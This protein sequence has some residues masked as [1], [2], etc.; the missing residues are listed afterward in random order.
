MHDLSYNL[1]YRTSFDVEATSPEGDALWVVVQNIRRWICAKW[2]RRGV[3]IPRDDPA[4]SAFK[5]GRDA[6]LNEGQGRVHFESAAI[7]AGE[8]AE[9]WACS[10]EETV[11]S[12]VPS[13]APRVWRTEVG[14]VG[15]SRQS[16][17]LSLILSYGDMPGFVGPVQPTPTASVPNLVRNLASDGRLSCTCS[18]R[19]VPTGPIELSAGTVA[20]FWAFVSDSDR[21]TP[22][23][24]VSPLRTASR[25]E[26]L[27]V[28]PEAI[29]RA[30]GP[31][32]FVFFTRDP[33]VIGELETHIGDS[34]LRCDGGAMRVYAPHPAFSEDADHRKHRFLTAGTIRAFGADEV[35]GV[36]RRAL[37]RDVG[38][39]EGL[40]RVE[41]VRRRLRMA[42]VEKYTKMSVDE[43]RGEL[44]DFLLG[45]E[46]T[47]K[48]KEGFESECKVLR[49][50]VYG[51][52]SQVEG[53][54]QALAS[55]GDGEGRPS[56]EDLPLTLGSCDDVVMTF[57]TLFPDRVAFT[58]RA[59]RS[60]DRCRTS[61]PVLAAALYALAFLGRDL[62]LSQTGVDI[63][64]EFKSRSGFGLALDNGSQTRADPALMAGFRD[65]YQGRAIECGWHVKSGSD[66][67]SPRFVRIYFGFDRETGRV[68]VSCLAHL[69]T[70][71]T[72][73][74]H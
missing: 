45:Y 17:S 14:F 68:V 33:G 19:T 48:E 60:L 1:F 39:Y 7:W 51:L 13:E 27:L 16:G 6:G 43:V 5:A 23:V 28:D 72:Q 41:T 62:L 69:R 56:V 2:E 40:T 3:A 58:K 31:S 42:R 70:Y 47:L 21:A 71:A 4:W 10:I 36:L 25:D 59:V 65:A 44:D 9:R 52:R 66:E 12:D 64:Q 30:L 38:L 67:S 49:Q 32:A 22:V 11:P 26:A 37:A 57:K 55:R 35:V 61:P 53:L 20:D 54:T 29:S 18:G 74:R 34:R 46:E 8:V 50:S 73:F 15:R 63:T 24:L